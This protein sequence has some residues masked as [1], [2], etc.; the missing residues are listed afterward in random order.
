MLSVLYLSR[1][2]SQYTRFRFRSLARWLS[3]A[4]SILSFCRYPPRALSLQ[5]AASRVAAGGR[6]DW[7]KALSV[8]PSRR[9][10]GDPGGQGSET[11]PATIEKEWCG[12][13]SQQACAY[14]CEYVC[15]YICVYTYIAIHSS[16]SIYLSIYLSIPIC[17]YLYLSMAMYTYLYLAIPIYRSIELSIYRSI[18]ELDPGTT[19]AC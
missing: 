12:T 2:L 1:P 7:K 11:M 8:E 6:L 9:G 18:Y 17:T 14:A 19:L 10:A 13:H 5:P 16:R 4:P 3:P 15:M